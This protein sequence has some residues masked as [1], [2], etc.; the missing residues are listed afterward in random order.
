MLEDMILPT[1][2]FDQN[3]TIPGSFFANGNIATFHDGS[4]S[5]TL[6]AAL[7]DAIDPKKALVH[8]GDRKGSNAHGIAGG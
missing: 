7:R 8:L 3:V 5:N 2:S 4:D 1:L 6:H